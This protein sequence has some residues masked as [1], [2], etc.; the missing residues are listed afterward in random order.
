VLLLCWS[1]AGAGCAPLSHEARTT[2]DPRTGV[3]ISVADEP[4][5]LARER[6][7]LAAQARDYLTLIAT[8]INVAGSRRLLLCVHEW[9]TIDARARGNAAPL[10]TALLLVA[11][12]RDL[13]LS[14]LAQAP[15]DAVALSR[16]LARPADAEVYTTFYPIEPEALRYLA[17]AGHLS[18]AFPA[19]TPPLPF[20]LWRDGRAAQ[21]RLLDAIGQ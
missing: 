11:D 5:V 21:L 3:S 15:L 2:L 20:G 8:E 12:G 18:A 19:R 1:L 4:L 10:P 14:P 7:D 13:W 17:S 16:E 6:R 9:S